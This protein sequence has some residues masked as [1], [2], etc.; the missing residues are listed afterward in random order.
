MN[1]YTFMFHM[2][3]YDLHCIFR[4]FV[5]R[6]PDVYMCTYVKKVKEKNY[7]LGKVVGNFLPIIH[8]CDKS[9]GN[10][11]VNTHEFLT[12]ITFWCFCILRHSHTL[13]SMSYYV[14]LVSSFTFLFINVTIFASITS[15][16]L[17]LGITLCVTNR[18]ISIYIYTYMFFM[19]RLFPSLCI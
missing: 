17:S 15:V 2:S 14:F 9:V 8:E 7:A 18:C 6:Y 12:K 19:P 3:V 11:Y 5:R 16:C 1:I 13:L 10:M 4:C